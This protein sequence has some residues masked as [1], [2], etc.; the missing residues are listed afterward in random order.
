M[1]IKNFI[2]TG[3]GRSGTNFLA[4]IMNNSKQWIVNHEPRGNKDEIEKNN[5][6]Y[7]NEVL[8]HI[9]SKPYYGEVNSYLRFHFMRIKTDK[10]GILLRSPKKIFLSVM[11]RKN[12]D[13][14]Y[15]QFAN[16]ISAWYDIFSTILTTDRQITPII[17]EKITTDVNYLEKTLYKFNVKDVTITN[18]LLDKVVNANKSIKY[19]TFNHLPSNI[20]LYAQ[21][22]LFYYDDIIDR[23]SDI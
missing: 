9:F 6:N 7:P 1:E 16:D 21:K 12:Y 14:H 17:F 3:Y 18:N 19:P 2:I 20:Q 15:K 13:Q 5:K 23:F 8:N 11:N 10:K 4:D 22:K